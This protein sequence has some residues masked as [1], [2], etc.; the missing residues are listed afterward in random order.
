M[1]I[2]DEDDNLIFEASEIINELTLTVEGIG[3]QILGNAQA[4]QG[5]VNYPW[6]LQSI[7]HKLKSLSELNVNDKSRVLENQK[8]MILLLQIDML[9]KL[10][11]FLGFGASGAIYFGIKESD[12]KKGNFSNTYFELQNS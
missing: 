6:A 10:P 11:D 4:V 1:N 8:K 9:D 2:S 5:D 12:L 3:H 7:G